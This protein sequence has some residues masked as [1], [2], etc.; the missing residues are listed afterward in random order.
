MCKDSNLGF[1]GFRDNKRL[2]SETRAKDYLKEEFKERISRGP[3]KYKLQLTLH[4]ARPDDPPAILNIARYWDQATHPWLDVADVTLTALL[5]PD[6][7]DGF[8]FSCGNLPSPLYFLPARS[9]YDSNCVAHIRKEVYAR[10]QKI[11]SMRSSGQQPDHKATYVISVETGAQK[12]AGT[13]ANISVSLTGKGSAL[14]RTVVL[15]YGLTHYKLNYTHYIDPYS[16]FTFVLL[17]FTES[18]HLWFLKGTLFR[19]GKKK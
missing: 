6:V 10:T 8:K 15:L 5:T 11:R 18:D 17:F 19:A 14:I 2:P 7:T 3:V 16:N 9:I 12:K 4:E 13:N 1:R